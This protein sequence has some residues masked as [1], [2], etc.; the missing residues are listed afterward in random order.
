MTCLIRR[1]GTQLPVALH[2]ALLLGLLSQT[3]PGQSLQTPSDP[4]EKSWRAL[5]K[6]LSV[7]VRTPKDKT[8]LLRRRKNRIEQLNAFVNQHS[9]KHAESPSLLK[10]RHELALLCLRSLRTSTADQQ[11]KAI[12]DS[13]GTD[14]L[15]IHSSA[16]YGLAQLRELEGETGTAKQLLGRLI[17]EGS[18]TRY[19]DL[20][21]AA[22]KRLART[23][24]LKTNQ[25]V[26]DF[27]SLADLQHH[28][29]SRNELRGSPSLL[30]F[31]SADQ[32]ESLRQIIFAAQLPRSQVIAF[33]IG[34]DAATLKRRF[35]AKPG[36]PDAIIVHLDK[37]FLEDVILDY[38]VRS[39]PS[40]YL[41]D[42]Q[43]KF[44]ARNLPAHQLRRAV[45]QARSGK[46]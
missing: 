32:P 2:V 22:L 15:D 29:H 27:R 28:R 24:P 43:C 26:P 42:S 31:W 4:I 10:A 12:L 8:P 3:L 17:R 25:L 14:Q 5:Q 13:T 30:I 1:Q 40:T 41:L 36:T 37:A 9:E 38:G 45:E 39:L 44:V 18:G 20:A 35:A 23:A 34:S 11:F 21:K 7:P 16:L 6:K 46:K 19:T 33:V